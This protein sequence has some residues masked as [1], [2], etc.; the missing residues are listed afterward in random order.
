MA[1]C[2]QHGALC[3]RRHDAHVFSQIVGGGRGSKTAASFLE[4]CHA[5]NGFKLG[6]LAPN[7]RLRLAQLAGGSRKGPGVERGQ[8]GARVVPVEGL[9]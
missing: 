1:A 9:K 5:Q 2:H 7:G 3:G 4:E 8:K 6:N